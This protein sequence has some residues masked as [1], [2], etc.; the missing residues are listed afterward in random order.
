M[1]A[2]F[3]E[4]GNIFL[5]TDHFSIYAIALIEPLATNTMTLDDI[6]DGFGITNQFAVFTR[7]MGARGHMEG[8]IAVKEMEL[9]EGPTF[10][11]GNTSSVGSNAGSSKN[12]NLKITKITKNAPAVGI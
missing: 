12:V 7:R 5:D 8:S 11:F 9:L 1:E 3:D 4:Y 10:D 6:I 2:S